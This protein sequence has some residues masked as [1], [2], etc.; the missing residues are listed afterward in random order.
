M[1]CAKCQA[2]LVAGA[3]FCQKCGAPT[4]A[5][6]P[7]EGAATAAAPGEGV[8]SAPERVTA[9]V[10]AAARG[11]DAEEVLWEG[12]FSKLAMIGAWVGAGIATL[13]AIVVGLVIG[14]TSGSWWITLGVLA[15]LWVALVLRLLY[16][17][18]SIKYTL[19]NQRLIHERGILWQT[20]DRIEAIDIDD[21]TVNQGPV[22]RMLG[23]GT[24]HVVSSDLSTPKFALT[25]IED[26]RNV[27]TLIDNARRKERR[28]RGLHIET[29]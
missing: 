15:A 16:Q 14:L 24:V 27:A 12:R 25:G 29:M 9:A 1:K 11:P 7:T 20:R 19:T 8:Q 4:G 18:M 3:A 28:K 6:A 26:V 2:E 21:V 5:N 23:V 22:E 17:Q 10:E 13:V